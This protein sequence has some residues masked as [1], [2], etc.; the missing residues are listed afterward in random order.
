VRVIEGDPVRSLTAHT[1]DV[2][3]LT[4]VTVLGIG[5]ATILRPL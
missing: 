4:R 2:G 1:E 5:S 3:D